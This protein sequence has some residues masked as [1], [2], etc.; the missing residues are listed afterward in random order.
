MAKFGRVGNVKALEITYGA[1][2]W[3]PHVHEVVFASPGAQDDLDT[4]DA[5]KDAWIAAVLKAGLAE[6]GQV[7]DMLLHAFDFQAGAFVVDYIAKF[8]REPAPSSRTVSATKDRWGIHSEATRFVSKV[9]T[10]YRKGSEYIGLTPFG[11]LADAVENGDEESRALFATYAHAFTG[12]RQLTWTPKLKKSLAIVELED[13][14]IAA[15][16]HEKPAEEF[17]VRLFESDWKTV[18]QHDRHGARYTLLYVAQ[19]YGADGVEAFLSML[20]DARPSNK[21][22]FIALYKT[23]FN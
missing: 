3:H 10:V 4:I 20:R 15:G 16:K 8:G 1:H 5:L 22:D 11:L 14:E 7:E 6:H 21:G 19:K 18:L 13:E 12:K 2:G 9:G 17:V 23:H